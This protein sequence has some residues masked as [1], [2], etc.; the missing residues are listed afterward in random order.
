M[1]VLG[2]LY[3]GKERTLLSTGVVRRLRLVSAKGSRERGSLFEHQK[4]LFKQQICIEDLQKSD[5]CQ[6]KRFDFVVV[7]LCI[8]ARA[9]SHFGQTDIAGLHR[10]QRKYDETTMSHSVNPLLVQIDSRISSLI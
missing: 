9:L 1:V 4:C 3:E 7:V 5:A 10:C 2:Y 8:S 6:L